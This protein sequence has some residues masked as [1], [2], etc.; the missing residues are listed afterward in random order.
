[1]EGPSFEPTISE[2]IASLVQGYVYSDLLSA[3]F[4]LPASEI[5]KLQDPDVSTE[6]K[7][8]LFS[9][10]WDAIKHTAYARVTRKILKRVYGV[11]ELDREALELVADKLQPADETRYF[12]R[13]E[14]AGIKALLV[15]VLGWA[16]GGIKGYLHGDTSFPESFRPLI[17]LP[18]MHPTSFSAQT[19]Y[20]FGS[21]ID[22]SVTSLDDFLEII[23]EI[24]RK[25]IDLGAIGI[26]DQSAYSRGLDYDLATRAEA[27]KQFNSVLSDP[28]GVLGWP[29][30]KPLNDYL[31][32]Q[33]MRFAAE[34]GIPVQLHTGHMAGIRSRVTD[35]NAAHLRKVLEV[36]RDVR[37]DLF[38][39]NWPY[40][41]DLLFLGKNYPNVALD[42]CWVHIIDPD[43]SV[44]LVERAVKVLP[45]TKIHGFGGDYGD[46][47]DYVLAH[48]E[49]ARENLALALSNLVDSGWMSRNDALV[50]ARGWLY[51]YPNEFFSLGL[52]T[53]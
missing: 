10:L 20:E 15:D 33:Y 30:G 17:S 8:P 40:M 42:L 52:P 46:F 23:F 29:E 38:H 37:F 39:G 12:S 43:Y 22:R 25:S 27:E 36:H 49:I 18:G 16:R 24:L 47:P 53:Q 32:H 11:E 48:L 28:R 2:P 34:L 44:E 1:M 41:G 7:W 50:L 4:G 13:L 6:D 26:K 3:A 5:S 9:R 19:I 14:E 21:A 51:D 31:F 45:H 35:A